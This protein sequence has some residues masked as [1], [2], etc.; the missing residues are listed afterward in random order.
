MTDFFTHFLKRLLPEA[1]LGIGLLLWGS[2]CS[3]AWGQATGEIQQLRI[4]RLDD[5]VVLS[6][7]LQFDLPATIED[8]LAKGIPLTF[9][10]EAEVY[11]ERWYWFDKRVSLAQR[12]YRLGYQPLS[13][14][15]RVVVLG[16]QGEGAS[17]SMSQSY[18]SLTEA[19]NAI[20]RIARWRIAEAAQLDPTV[21]HR[22]EFR[23]RL[24]VNQLA[25]PLQI[26]TLGQSDWNV[27]LTATAALPAGSS[28]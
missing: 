13:R 4:E 8:V 22:V 14:R 1:W 11:R 27:T 18:E 9:T 12:S 23:Y 7:Q 24:D 3:Q 25:V 2:L 5:E 28:K 10:A 19:M 21:S 17:L 15:W 16:P 6:A 20:K 26:G